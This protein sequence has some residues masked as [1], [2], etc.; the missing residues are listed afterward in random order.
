MK[1]Y[2]SFLLFV[3]VSAIMKPITAMMHY[4]QENWKHKLQQI[5][6]TMTLVY[7]QNY[8]QNILS[9]MAIDSKT[10]T[11][12]IITTIYRNWNRYH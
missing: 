7:C 11:S 3:S 4:L 8:C 9:A 12:I 1:C 5:L 6:E 10:K 2:Y